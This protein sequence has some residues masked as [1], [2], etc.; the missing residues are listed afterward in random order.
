MMRTLMLAVCATVLCISQLDAKPLH[1]CTNHEIKKDSRLRTPTA[2]SCLDEG[3]IKN[4]NA[5]LGCG[6]GSDIGCCTGEPNG[7][8]TCD[9]LP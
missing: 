5:W 6:P 1:L 4:T 9:P 7:V 2:K 8:A 3:V